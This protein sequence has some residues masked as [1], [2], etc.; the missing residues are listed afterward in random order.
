METIISVGK[1]PT[2]QLP[3]KDC[4]TYELKW[5]ILKFNWLCRCCIKDNKDYLE[6]HYL[7]NWSETC[8]STVDKVVSLESETVRLSHT[9]AKDSETF[10]NSETVYETMWDLISKSLIS[11]AKAYRWLKDGKIIEWEDWKFKFT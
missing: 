9:D 11:K 4:W 2:K 5:F 3:C 8:I 10:F 7:W 6:S 1:I